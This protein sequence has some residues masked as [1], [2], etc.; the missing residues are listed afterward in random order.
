MKLTNT[1]RDAFIRAAMADVP[2]VDYQEK[3]IKV[4]MADA[5][6]QLPPKVKA[7]YKEFPQFVRHD[8]C[9]FGNAY[10]SVPCAKGEHF[11]LSEKSA[12]QVE[13][14]KSDL[15]AQNQ[16]NK[17]LRDKLR[18]VAYSVNTR[19]ALADALPEFEKYLP[20]DDAAACRTLPVVANVVADFVKAGWPKGT[21]K[22]TL[23]AA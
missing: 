8:G 23:K 7:F 18:A 17:E 3:T 16:R 19:K 4:V 13:Q 14:L 10:V 12:A 15:D 9:Y 22:Q 20:A 5:V 21:K 1:I 2:D 11:K 6:A